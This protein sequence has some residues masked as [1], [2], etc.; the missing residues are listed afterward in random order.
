MNFEK[1][2]SDYLN[3]QTP[4]YEL[5]EEELWL[6]EWPDPLDEDWTSEVDGACEDGTSSIY[7]LPWPGWAHIAVETKDIKKIIEINND[8][9]L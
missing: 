6:L 2:N 4:P 9:Y 5:W 8:K 3:D 7:S 1:K